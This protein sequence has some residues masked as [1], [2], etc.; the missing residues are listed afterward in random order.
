MAER[1]APPRGVRQPVIRRRIKR[2]NKSQ[3]RLKQSLASA[4]LLSLELP[5]KPKPK[6]RMKLPSGTVLV[7]EIGGFIDEPGKV[8]SAT[9]K[10][11]R[12]K[13]SRGT[14]TPGRKQLTQ[15]R[16]VDEPALPTADLVDV[17]LPP[18]TAKKVLKRAAKTPTVRASTAPKRV[19]RASSKPRTITNV[20][21]VPLPRKATIAMLRGTQGIR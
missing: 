21:A 17:L 20:R 5:P 4:R 14:N 18:V 13:T 7:D 15:S 19:V 3:A 11:V 10:K 8:P 9:K 12:L 16:S 2:R 1:K 6:P